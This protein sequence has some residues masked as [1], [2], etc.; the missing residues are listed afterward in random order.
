MWPATAGTGH[1]NTA[2]PSKGKLEMNMVQHRVA[3]TSWFVQETS[4]ETTLL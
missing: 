2:Q 4:T 3:Q 1:Q